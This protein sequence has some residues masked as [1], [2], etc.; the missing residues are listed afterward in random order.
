MNF[1]CRDFAAALLEFVGDELTPDERLRIEQHLCRCTPCAIF[2]Q[3]YRLTVRVGR[4]LAPV[5]VPGRLLERVRAA[6]A[7]GDTG[8]TA[9]SPT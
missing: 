5:A 3:Q 1:T 7:D 9:E 4:C 2:V 6:L 8:P